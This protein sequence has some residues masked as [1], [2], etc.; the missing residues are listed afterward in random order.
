MADFSK[1]CVRRAPA[2]DGEPPD[3]VRR[4]PTRQSQTHLRTLAGCVWERTTARMTT[5]KVPLWGLKAGTGRTN[6]TETTS[7]VGLT[8]LSGRSYSI[9]SLSTA[10][11]GLRPKGQRVTAQRRSSG[12]SRAKVEPLEGGLRAGAQGVTARRRSSGL[13]LVRGALAEGASDGGPKHPLA[14]ASAG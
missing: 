10:R 5:T 12:R 9:Q 3:C 6:R 11:C 2:E 8:Y 13:S 7:H 14:E 1:S 4:F